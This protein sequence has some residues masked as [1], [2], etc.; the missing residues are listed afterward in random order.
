MTTRTIE[1]RIDYINLVDTIFQDLEVDYL[2]YNNIYKN[3]HR[4]Y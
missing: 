4:L 2:L 3:G 1:T